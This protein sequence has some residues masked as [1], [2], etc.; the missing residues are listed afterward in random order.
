MQLALEYTNLADIDDAAPLDET[1]YACFAALRDVLKQHD[2]LD[3]FGVML[4]HSHFPVNEGETFLETCCSET[5]SMSLRV[6]N[7]DAIDKATVVETSWRL[8]DGATMTTCIKQCKTVNRRHQ[9]SHIKM[10]D[11]KP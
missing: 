1:D 7:K 11:V 10:A 4:L 8:T 3:R 2:K 5:R 6:I 9:Q